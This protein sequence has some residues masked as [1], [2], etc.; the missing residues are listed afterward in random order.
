MEKIG[1]SS[2][3]YISGEKQVLLHSFGVLKDKDFALVFKGKMVQFC[4]CV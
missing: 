2:S 1:V 3:R 4:S